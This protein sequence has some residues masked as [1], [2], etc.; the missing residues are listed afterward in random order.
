MVQ[1]S[2]IG[3]KLPLEVSDCRLTIQLGLPDL[4]Q[5]VLTLLQFFVFVF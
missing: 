4:I 5:F 2:L 1:L 3:L